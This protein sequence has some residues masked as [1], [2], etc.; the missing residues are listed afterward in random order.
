[1]NVLIIGGTG[2]ISSPM[3]RFFLERGDAVTHYNRG[4]MELYPA[5]PE[6]R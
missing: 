4:N 1:M 2:L 6:V 3:T 5:P